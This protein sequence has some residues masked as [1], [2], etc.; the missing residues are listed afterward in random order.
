MT[1]PKR[2]PREDHVLI[3]IE[4]DLNKNRRDVVDSNPNIHRFESVVLNIQSR[5]KR[6]KREPIFFENPWATV[7]DFVALGFGF[8]MYLEKIG[9]N[10]GNGNELIHLSNDSIGMDEL[11]IIDLFGCK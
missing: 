8:K 4:S 9:T 2:E 7:Q 5:I 1:V 3:A 10:R 11:L 6:G